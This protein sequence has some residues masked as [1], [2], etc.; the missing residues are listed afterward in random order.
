MKKEV[1]IKDIAEIAGVSIATVSKV[2]NNQG[3]VG[4]DTRK[5]ICKIIEEN[6]YSPN[7]IAVSMIR[8]MSNMIVV[9]VPDIFTRFY[10]EIVQGAEEVCK[11]RGFS[12]LIY[13]TGARR[14]EEFGFFGNS[15]A[16]MADGILCIPSF[17]DAAPY[18]SYGKS[19]VMVDRYVDN[20][21]IDGIIVD[22]FGGAYQ[23]TKHL[24]GQGIRQIAFISGP[25]TMNVGRDRLRGYTQAMTDAGLDPERDVYIRNWY[26]E[27]GYQ[28]VL[29]MYQNGREV[30]GGIVTGNSNIGIGAINAVQEIN[31][32]LSSG[33][34]IV[35]FDDCEMARF[36][37]ITTLKR[38]NILMGNIAANM[39]L[40][41][42]GNAQNHQMPQVITMPL[43]LIVRD[44]KS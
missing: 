32:N 13:T 27:D 4:E 39:L 15:F 21:L 5:R 33:P 6:H 35:C 12:A 43:E 24:T 20:C 40:D 25:L 41:K 31:G 29:D 37:K 16:R 36:A 1:T 28:A 30:P 42:I 26:E 14:E 17:N 7:H 9:M 23:L 18:R 44:V 8:K 10:A 19:L 34:K 22:N 3:R 38:N 11:E 2:I